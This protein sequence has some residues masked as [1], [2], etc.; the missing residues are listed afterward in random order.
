M[1]KEIVEA[2]PDAKLAVQ[3]VWLPM[4]PSDNEAAA[5]KSATVYSDRRFQQYYDPDRL[6]GIAFT[7]EVKL[8]DFQPLLDATPDEHPLKQRM[9]EWIALP[10]EQRALWDIAYFFPPGVEWTERLPASSRWTKQM[11]FWGDQPGDQPSG[12][13]LR[14]GSK[15]PPSE[16][17]WF[18]E[19]RE[20]MKKLLLATKTPAAS[21]SR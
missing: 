13:F 15:E 6:L 21:E 12:L 4:I 3:I 7:K 11:G 17:D 20:G 8:E 5:R 10:P 14:Q 19:I 9:K 1:Q 18:V 2:Y 16:S